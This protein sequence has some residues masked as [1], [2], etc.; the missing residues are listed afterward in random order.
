MCL[1]YLGSMNTTKPVNGNVSSASRNLDLLRAFA[2]LCVFFDHLVICQ[3]DTGHI[4]IG[5]WKPFAKGLVYLFGRF[6]VMAFF[7]HTALVLMISLESMSSHHRIRNFYVRRIFRLYPLSIL[8]IASILVF[9]IPQQTDLKFIPLSWDVVVA[10]L[11]LVQNIAHRSDM[12]GPLWTLPREIQMYLVLPFLY[13]LLRRF[14]SSTLILLLWF[15]CFAAVPLNVPLLSCVPCFIGGVL[16]Y[17]ISKERTFSLPSFVWPVSIVVLL[18]SYAAC[19]LFIL[20]DFRSDC[21]FCMFLGLVVPNV[22]DMKQSS[23]SMV[24]QTIAKY[25]YG[26]YL[27]H[28]PVLW[29][30][31]VKMAHLPV[32]IQWTIMTLLMVVIPIAAFRLV[33]APLIAIGRRLSSNVL[34]RRSSDPAGLP[35]AA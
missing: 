5:I 35:I 19:Y 9:Q 31:F 1:W 20:P 30:C 10:N 27:C 11:L 18:C 12:I 14:S 21:I 7:V 17:Q 33:E 28:V 29:F 4:N 23:I 34:A 22:L 24:C 13:V 6:G 2:V 25:S 26:I 3:L 15:A 8:C 32:I 16:A